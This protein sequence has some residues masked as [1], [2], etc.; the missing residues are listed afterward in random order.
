MLCAALA[1]WAALPPAHADD[2]A[3][4][5]LKEVRTATKAAKS[6]T[7]DLSISQIGGGRDMKASGT[8]KLRKPNLARVEI[9][10]PINLAIASDGK[11]T[12]MV[13]KDQNMYQKKA[14]D[15]NGANIDA[16]FAVQV[17]L[18]FTAGTTDTPKALGISLANSKFAGTEKRGTLEYQILEVSQGATGEQ[19]FRFFVAPSNLITGMTYEAGQGGRSVKLSCF[20]DNVKLNQDIST[21]AFAYKPPQTAKVYEEPNYEAKL[22]K[23]GAEAPPFELTNPSDKQ[24]FS[25]GKT[26]DARKAVL[27][28]FWF[29]N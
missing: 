19:K 5:L 14:A 27:V 20:L 22:L 28:N 26:L 3:T 2:K 8:V 7:A 11:D 18:F 25:L 23:V 15:A 10:A 21:T 6:L 1:A 12:Y 9:G 13:M 4:E 24:R 17:P 16:V 29:Y